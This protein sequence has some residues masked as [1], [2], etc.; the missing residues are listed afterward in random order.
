MS[1]IWIINS[2]LSFLN[3]FLKQPSSSGCSIKIWDGSLLQTPSGLGQCWQT[4]RR[5]SSGPEGGLFWASFRFFYLVPQNKQSAQRT[6]FSNAE[7]KAQSPLVDDNAPL[8][9]HWDFQLQ[10]LFCY[11]FH[12]LV[13]FSEISR[14]VNF[15][16]SLLLGR[17]G[18]EQMESSSSTTPDIF[19]GH[20]EH[21]SSTHESSCSVVPWNTVTNVHHT[22]EHF[23]W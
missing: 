4:A 20:T 1:C 12:W 22:P 8:S 11:C 14:V 13:A 16:V 2:I 10:Q 9:F 6:S 19:E 5:V 17:H 7:H 23:R 15:S 21:A 18:P 3:D